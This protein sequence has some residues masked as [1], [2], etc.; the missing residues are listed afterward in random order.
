MYIELIIVDVC[1]FW[2]VS[3]CYRVQFLWNGW[4]SSLWP[5]DCIRQK[6]MCEYA[7]TIHTCMCTS[8]TVYVYLIYNVR[9]PHLPY[10]CVPHL[11][12]TSSTIYMYLIYHMILYVYIIYNM[13]TSSTIC[14][15]HLQCAY[16]QCM[17][18]S[19]TMYVHL[20]YNVRAPHE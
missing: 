10:I 8:S 1:K 4:P 19:F 20:I 13:C 9:E 3:G 17:C 14:V 6:A 5:T 11:Q 16:I 2:P 15:H 12:C 18:I 7:S